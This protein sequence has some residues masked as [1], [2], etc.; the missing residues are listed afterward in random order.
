MKKVL[1]TATVQSHIGQFHRPLAEVLHENGYEVHVAARNNLAEK[2]GLELDFADKIYDVPF[3]R[4]PKSLDNIKAYRQLKKIIEQESYEVIHCNTPMGGIVTRL[5]AVGA[6][7]KGTKVFYTAHGFHFYQGAPKKN[8]LI[9]YPIE[10]V[11][12]RFCDT[13]I[14]I[15]KEDYLLAGKKFHTNIERIHGV[16]VYTDRYHSVNSETRCAMRRAENLEKEDYVILCTGELNDNK[17]QKTLIAATPILRDK[18]PNLKILLAG[19][20]PLEEKLRNQIIK[21]GLEDNIRLLGYRTDLEKITPA[22]DLVVSCS[23]REGLPLNILEAMLCKKPVVTSINRGHK[24]LVKND[25]N[26]YMIPADDMKQYISRI[27]M[28]YANPS[29]AAKMGMNGYRKAQAY[30]VESVKQELKRIYNLNDV[31]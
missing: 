29:Q 4:S 8:W 18:I 13:L 3:S 9:F 23:Y 17:N 1:L 26:G 6:R 7:R 5:A 12:A 25:F 21:R 15:T 27:C 11:M 28:L 20:G 10:R 16:G 22:V 19:N 2:N 30:T 14:A 31:G 24:E